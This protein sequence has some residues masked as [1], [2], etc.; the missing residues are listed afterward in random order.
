MFHFG[1]IFYIDINMFYFVTKTLLDTKV[2]S[3]KL[4]H[5]NCNYIKNKKEKPD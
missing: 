1:I 3:K 4:W 5:Y 2:T